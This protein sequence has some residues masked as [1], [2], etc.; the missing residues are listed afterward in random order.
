MITIEAGMEAY[1]YLDSLIA[2]MYKFIILN[3]NRTRSA[4]RNNEKGAQKCDKK[5]VGC[6]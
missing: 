4:M 5:Q 2:M 1:F 6:K 3:N